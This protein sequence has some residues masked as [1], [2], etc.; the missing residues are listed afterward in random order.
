M[1]MSKDME[2]KLEQVIKKQLEN[3]RNS[4]LIVGSKTMCAVILDKAK[5]TNKTDREKLE[6]IISFCERNVKIE[7]RDGD[8]K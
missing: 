5:A 6:D 8:K 4:G 7:K 1:A 3:A 2:K